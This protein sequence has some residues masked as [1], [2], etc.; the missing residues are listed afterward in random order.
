[1][2][3][4][5]LFKTKK[6]KT[7]REF[8]EKKKES[9]LTDGSS[10]PSKGEK[11]DVR[12]ES[13]RSDEDSPPIGIPS[14]IDLKEG[15]QSKAVVLVWMDSLV[16]AQRSKVTEIEQSIAKTKSQDTG[17]RYMEG[18]HKLNHI[19]ALEV[20]LTRAHQNISYLRALVVEMEK[21]S[22]EEFYKVQCLYEQEVLEQLNKPEPKPCHT[23]TWTA[24]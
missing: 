18:F 5:T 3:F 16:K 17:D 23:T 14:T 22:S 13:S 24:S 9:S 20:R 2:K 10:L 21:E 1:M 4:F 15:H 7:W 11:D 6:K 19:Q 8:D 12:E